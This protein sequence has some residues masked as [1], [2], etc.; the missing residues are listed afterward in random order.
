M[1]ERDR[2]AAWYEL[3]PAAPVFVS[4][5]VC[6]D[7]PFGVD[8]GV[9]GTGAWVSFGSCGVYSKWGMAFS[10]D[11]TTAEW[12]VEAGGSWPV[13]DFPAIDFSRLGYQDGT[14][15][16]SGIAAPIFMQ[17]MSD[18]ALDYF[19]YDINQFATPSESSNGQFSLTYS[20]QSS[21]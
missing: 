20:T 7:E 18:E 1:P 14:E 4:I 8:V 5:R 16:F 21:L 6:T 19:P 10:P 13:P 15:T 3:Y 12:V 17:T 2:F 9:N 11:P